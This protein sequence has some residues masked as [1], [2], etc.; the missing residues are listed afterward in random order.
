[1]CARQV[2]VESGCALQ[3]YVEYRV[4]LVTAQQLL[5]TYKLDVLGYIGLLSAVLG[6]SI[7]GYWLL[8]M[9]QTFTLE[10]LRMQRYNEQQYDHLKKKP[11]TK[12]GETA[13]TSME[14]QVAVQEVDSTVAEV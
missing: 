2:C 13:A 12:G 4:Q 10:K 1:M 3:V 11:S 9:W 14:P 8:K 7:V 6:L 5:V